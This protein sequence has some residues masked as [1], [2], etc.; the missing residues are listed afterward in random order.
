MLNPLAAATTAAPTV[1]AQQ[2]AMPV[3]GQLSPD[4]PPANLGDL[5]RGPIRQGMSEM[6]F[7]EGQNRSCRRR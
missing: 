1:R 7:V 3:I 2:K 6:G 5:L 4:S